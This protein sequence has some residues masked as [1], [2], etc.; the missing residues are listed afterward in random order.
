MKQY[1]ILLA[2][3]DPFLL[4]GVGMVLEKE[5]YKVTTAESGEEAVELLKKTEFDLVMTDQVMNGLNGTQV[6]K[7]VKE[8]NPVTK[9]II[10]TGYDTLAVAIDALRLHADDFLLKPC[11]PKD[12]INK[13]KQCLVNL[14]LSRKIKLYEKILPICGVCKKIRDDEGTEPGK[15]TWVDLEEYL[16]DKAKI[17]VSHGYCPDCAEKIKNEY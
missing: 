2:D 3:D 8:L 13:V 9:V 4:T 10:L 6:L 7:K 1:E 17:A 16:L 15:G 14:E 12:M 5:G 11:D